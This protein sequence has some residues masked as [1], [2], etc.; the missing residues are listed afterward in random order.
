MLLQ[1]AGK[2]ND[3]KSYI[4]ICNVQYIQDEDIFNNPGLFRV[5]LMSK[6]K[7]ETA[8]K[9]IYI[10]VRSQRTARL[11]NIITIKFFK[12]NKT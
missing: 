3:T 5:E 4:Y 12:C 2:F 7:L 9:K 10:Y 1:D 8:E 6:S 11:P